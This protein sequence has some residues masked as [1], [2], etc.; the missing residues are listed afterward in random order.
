MKSL[1]TL[2]FTFLSFSVYGQGFVFISE[3][4]L[5]D[6]QEVQG[7]VTTTYMYLNRTDQSWIIT[8]VKAS[9]DCIIPGWEKKEIK[10]GEEGVLEV[11]FDPVHKTGQFTGL[12]SVTVKPYPEDVLA[13]A[14]LLYL[15][16]TANV[17]PKPKE[18]AEMYPVKL[19]P[20]RLKSNYVQFDTVFTNSKRPISCLLYNDS[21]DTVVISGYN[22]QPY[23]TPSSR[24]RLLPPRDTLSV[25]FTIDGANADDWGMVYYPV[26]ILINGKT[27]S[28]MAV[29]L[30]GYRGDDIAGMSEKQI[31]SAP[32]AV[33]E[34]RDF[35]FGTI[36]QGASVEH[37]FRIKNIGKEDLII[38]KW[39]PGCGC[40]SSQPEKTI[41]APGESTESKA[42]F[43]SAGQ[44]GTITKSITVV[45]NDPAEPIVTL[46]INGEVQAQ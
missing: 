24:T 22:V 38:R 13:S 26:Y 29:T 1:Y 41:L 10:A 37:T 14:D 18:I 17:I 36:Q 12:I 33:F 34:S 6:V 25:E 23:I 32:K 19:G 7:P 46:F 35:N 5:G 9:C 27:E 20:L 16:L 4:N 11:R 43:H 8:D 15:N 28:D 3:K 31:K 40:T 2:F 21:P 44:K 30:Y 42:I 39:K 45:T